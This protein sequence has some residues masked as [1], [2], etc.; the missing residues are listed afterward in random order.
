MSKPKLIRITTVPVS[1]DKLLEGQLAFMKEYFN[2]LAVS[3]DKNYLEKIGLREGVNTYTIELTRKITP[4]KDIRALYKMYRLF[5]KE[6]PFIV[7]THTPKAGTIGMVAAWLA[8]VPHRLHTIAGLPL[9]ETKGIK[10]YILT[11]VE[12]ATYACATDIYSNSYGLY[13]IILDNNFLSPN[14]IKVLGHGSSNGINLSFFNPRLF[15]SKFKKK[16]KD[17]FNIQENDYVFIYVGRVV[18]N[19][20]INELVRAF[21]ELQLIYRDIKLLLVGT[22][23]NDLDPLS[24]YTYNQI[25][26]NKNIIYTG[27]QTDVRPFLAIAKLFVFPSYREGFPNVVMQAGAMGLPSIVTDINGCNEII[28]NKKNGI[29]IPPKNAEILKGKM[30]LLLLDKNLYRTLQKNT[31]KMI[32]S[33]YQQQLIWDELLCEYR[34]LN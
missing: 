11:A 28:K 31:R 14:K 16:I 27:Y 33:R 20:G 30:E 32:A 10:R 17:K 7:H 4:V 12:K 9:L 13:K 21:S 8:N 3:S 26:I 25:Q 34:K 6:K 29:I 1:L 19:K 2:I 5:L 18:K 15:D 22:F 23:E 24:E